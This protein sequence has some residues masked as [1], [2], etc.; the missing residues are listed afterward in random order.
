[1]ELVT[2]IP[3]ILSDGQTSLDGGWIIKAVHNQMYLTHHYSIRVLGGINQTT[4][5]QRLP[6]KDPGSGAMLIGFQGQ[7]KRD[8]FS[9]F[10]SKKLS[11]TK[12]TR[13]PAWCYSH[14]HR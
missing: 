13:S 6:I 8:S 4:F 2:N 5:L 11:K 3:L 12:Q 14:S 10:V 7:L 9:C 1:M